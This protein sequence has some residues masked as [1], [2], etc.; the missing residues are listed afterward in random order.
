MFLLVVLSGFLCFFSMNLMT[1]PFPL[2]VASIV[3]T[4]AM[5]G[6]VVSIMGAVAIALRPFT[7]HWGDRSGRRNLLL[8]GAA[9]F[10]AAPLIYASSSSV[11]A[12]IAG[13]VVQ[14]MGLSVFTTGYGALVADLAPQGRRGQAI[15]LGALGTPMSLMLA[16]RLGATIQA[17]V[18]LPILFAI[19]ALI[20]GLS[21]FLLLWARPSTLRGTTSGSTEFRF[22]DALRSRRLRAMIPGILSVSLAYGAAF[23]FLPLYATE[24]GLAGASLFYVLF[25]ASLLVTGTMGGHLSDRVGRGRVIAPGMLGLAASLVALQWVRSLPTLVLVGLAYGLCLG[26]ARIALDAYTIDC[27]PECG[28]GSAI[29]L[30]YLV[31]DVGAGLG[32]LPL[33]AVAGAVGYGWMYTFV[34]GVCLAGLAAFRMMERRTGGV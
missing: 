30:E 24:R 16:P 22:G 6:A 2:Y 33:G 15:G 5:V 14:G 7:G 25:G 28:R 13:R 10:A 20:G 12:L 26:A 19:C 21:L 29:G 27:V 3:S 34:A 18:G 4:P 23:T 17:S 1:W 8:V 32:A 11:P 9:G 31:F